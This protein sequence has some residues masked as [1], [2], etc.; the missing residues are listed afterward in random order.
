MGKEYDFNRG[1]RGRYAG[2]LAEP[3]NVIVLDP[4]APLAAPYIIFFRSSS[5]NSF[6]TGSPRRLCPRMREIFPAVPS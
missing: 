4:D 5:E 2:R 3:R 6:S 1:V